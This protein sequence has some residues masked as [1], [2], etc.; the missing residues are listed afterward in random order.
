MKR[1]IESKADQ[2]F[3]FPNSGKSGPDLHTPFALEV[4]STDPLGRMEGGV[5]APYHGL[6]FQGDPRGPQPV[7]GL[8]PPGA[9]GVPLQAQIA[10]GPAG[11]AAQA[12]QQYSVS[13]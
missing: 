11:W 5:A 1:V 7:A 8:P 13:A 10:Q 4:Q 6:Q 9:T 2:L 12:A 3:E